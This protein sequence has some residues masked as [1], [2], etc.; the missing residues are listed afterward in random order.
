MEPIAPYKSVSDSIVYHPVSF[1]VLFGEGADNRNKVKIR[2]TKS[3]GTR[4]SDAEIKSRVINAI[5][6]YFDVGLWDF[7]E[8]FYFTD[9]ASWVHQNVSGVISSIALVPQQSGLTSNDMFQIKCDEDEI[10]IS[11]AT[12]AD[13]EV[14]TSQVAP[15][16]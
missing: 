11:S 15:T 4:I 8:T 3:D 7:G 9:M 12:V 6:N 5:N 16:K 1:K 13:V 10:F 14:I 2:V